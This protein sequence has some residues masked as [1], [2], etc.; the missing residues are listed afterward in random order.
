MTQTDWATIASQ[1]TEVSGQAFTVVSTEPLSGGCINQ[2]WRL[3]GKNESYFVKL[4]SVVHQDMF[5]AEMAGLREIAAT[6]TIAVPAPLCYGTTAR[7]SYL[8]LEYLDMRAGGSDLANE[9]FGEHLAAMHRCTMSQFG[10][11]QDNTIGL[12]PQINSAM[13]DWVQFWAQHRL[14]YQLQLA[15]SNGHHGRLQQRGEKLLSVFETLFVGH[16]PKPSLLHGDLWAG[17]YSSM[18]DGRPVIFDPTVYYGDRETDLA[19]TEL[20]GGFSPHF[21]QAYKGFWPLDDGYSIRKTLYNLYHI[22]NHLNLFGGGYLSQ[23]EDMVDQLLA[24]MG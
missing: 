14:A 2:A 20:F 7:Q 19:M 21:Y 12:T 10:W 13:D 18:A 3:N 11:S 23:A 8:V 1:I 9:Q 5:T 24:E 22:L 15:A 16:N 17:N 4:N 6:N